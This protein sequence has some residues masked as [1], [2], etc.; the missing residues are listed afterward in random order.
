MRDKVGDKKFFANNEHAKF[1]M[2]DTVLFDDDVELSIH[3]SDSESDESFDKLGIVCI[4][5]TCDS[6]N[7]KGS[8]QMNEGL[9]CKI[10]QITYLSF[11]TNT[12]YGDSCASCI[13]DSDK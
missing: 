13:I 2:Q 10:N 7:Q 5:D 9:V 6:P 8:S 11:T 12:W 3:R 4:D 1:S